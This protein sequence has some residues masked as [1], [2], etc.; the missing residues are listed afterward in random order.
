MKKKIP[1][2]KPVIVLTDQELA[3]ATGGKGKV[4]VQDLHFVISN[5]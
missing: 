1:V 4:I 2:K 5:G 3:S